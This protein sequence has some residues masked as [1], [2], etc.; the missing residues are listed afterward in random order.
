MQNKKELGANFNP[1]PTA[2]RPDGSREANQNIIG[3]F[4]NFDGLLSHIATQWA[5]VD[6]AA[7]EEELT[8]VPE[9]PKPEKSKASKPSTVSKASRVKPLKTA[10]P[11]SSVQSE[12]HSRVSKKTKKISEHD[13]TPAAILRN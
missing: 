5:T 7:D 2:P 1:G 4:D 8:E 9:P 3:P 12:D 6:E 11:E 10:P 13:L